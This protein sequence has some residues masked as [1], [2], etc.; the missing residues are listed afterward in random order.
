MKDIF[1]ETGRLILRKI[2]NND[3]YELCKMLQDAEVMYAWERTFPDEEVYDW[4]ARMNKLYDEFGYGY[5]LAIDKNTNEVIGQIGI[6][7]EK[8]NGETLIGVGYILKK[9]HWGKGYATEGA[10]GCIDYAFNRLKARKVIADIRPQ[11]FSSR[12]VAERIG[13]K[14]TGEYLKDVRGKEMLHLIYTACPENFESAKEP[15]EQCFAAIK[16]N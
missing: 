4:I 3:F 14:I 16:A 5:F 12:M 8:I 13:M 6:L 9:E 10:K 7:P 11:N 1:L 2:T 15:E